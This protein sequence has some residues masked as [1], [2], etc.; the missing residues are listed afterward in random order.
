MLKDNYSDF[1]FANLKNNLTKHIITHV[2]RIVYI[3]LLVSKFSN[4]V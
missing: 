2:C 3:K 1:L 4:Q